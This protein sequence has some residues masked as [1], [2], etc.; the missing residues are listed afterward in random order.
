MANINTLQNKKNVVRVNCTESGKTVEAELIR[1]AK[2]RIE[3]ILPGFIK[4]TL[5]KDPKPHFYV[6]QRA[7]LEFTCYTK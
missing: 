5:F 4:M 6:G 7:G 2:N 1:L 3:V